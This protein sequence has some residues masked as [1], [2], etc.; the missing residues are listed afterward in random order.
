[1][2]L[3]SICSFDNEFGSRVAMY[4]EMHF[5]LNRLEKSPCG[6]GIFIV[7]E[8]CRVQVRHFLV[9]HTLRQADLTDVL[10]LAFEVLAL[11]P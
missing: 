3:F 1:M 4:R 9:E 8:C 6:S 7:V 11:C 5:I 10:Q 2:F